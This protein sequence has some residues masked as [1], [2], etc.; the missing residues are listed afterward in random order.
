MND[1]PTITICFDPNAKQSVLDKL[2]ITIEELTSSKF[3]DPNVSISYPELYHSIAFRIG[4]DFNITLELHE[5]R[6]TLLIDREDIS[7]EISQTISKRFT[8]TNEIITLADGAVVLT[9]E[10]KLFKSVKRHL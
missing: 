9:A 7:E 6:Y 5:K 3:R 1:R 2:N 8:L 10:L 4:I